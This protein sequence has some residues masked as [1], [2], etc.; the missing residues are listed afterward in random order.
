MNDVKF[1]EG[2]NQDYSSPIVRNAKYVDFVWRF[3][4]SLI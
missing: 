4:T 2:A 1:Q 3:K